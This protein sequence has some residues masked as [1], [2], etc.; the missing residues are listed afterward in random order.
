MFFS[1]RELHADYGNWFAP[2]GPA[3]LGMCRSAGFSHAELRTVPW[4]GPT[5]T[6]RSTA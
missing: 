2:T 4:T 6:S 5:G 1:G 3:L